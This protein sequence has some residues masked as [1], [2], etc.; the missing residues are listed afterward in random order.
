MKRILVALGLVWMVSI[1]HGQDSTGDSSGQ[2]AGYQWAK[3]HNV[4]DPGACFGD[5][6][7]FVEGCQ[8]YAQENANKDSQDLNDTV[9]GE[10][11]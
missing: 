5:D 2:D 8:A 10:S 6:K 7:S 9:E 4:D 1:A 3:E 11:N